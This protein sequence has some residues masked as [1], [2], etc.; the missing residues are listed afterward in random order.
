MFPDI[1]NEVRL[2]WHDDPYKYLYLRETWVM[3]P[4]RTRPV[5]PDAFGADKR[6]VG[7]A[8]LLKDAPPSS[9]SPWG[10]TYWHRRVW[11]LYLDDAGMPK[12]KGVYGPA[13]GRYPVEAVSPHVIRTARPSIMLYE[14]PTVADLERSDPHLYRLM[15]WL[16]RCG[17][18]ATLREVQRAGL[19]GLETARSVLEAVGKLAG[20]SWCW[21]REERRGRTGQRVLTVQL[22]FLAGEGI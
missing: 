15:V 3:K 7:Y 20:L 17:G 12:D 21:L 6:V 8:V 5:A 16:V 18:K 9:T 4:S 19:P 1:E 14:R 22:I 13:T 10:R 2:E 11:W